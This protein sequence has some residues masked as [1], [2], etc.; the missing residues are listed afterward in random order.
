MS[1]PAFAAANDGYAL[2]SE[3]ARFCRR[4]LDAVTKALREGETAG[5]GVDVEFPREDR[6]QGLHRIHQ[7]KDR[8]PR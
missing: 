7:E 4:S 3:I 5:R 8:E 1:A 2:P 6:Q